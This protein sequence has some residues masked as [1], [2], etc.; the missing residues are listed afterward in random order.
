MIDSKK[1]VKAAAAVIL[2]LV[3]APARAD[4]GYR[5]WLRYDPLEA[6]FRTD[7]RAHAT[8]LVSDAAGDTSRA[9]IG[10]LSRGLGDL[11]GSSL[12]LRP[13]VDRD[14]A[15]LLSLPASPTARA[16]HVDAEGLGGEGYIIRSV[17]VNG[18]RA[19][20]ILANSETGLL[21]GAVGL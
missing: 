8:E 7:V 19:T 20:L 10:E 11:L 2:L 9:A 4:D 15:I 18:H 1:Q 3:A 5:L 12:P 14:G 6:P 21:Y 17:R 13:N 16:L